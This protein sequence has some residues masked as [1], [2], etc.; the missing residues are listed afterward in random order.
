MKHLNECA[1]SINDEVPGF[2]LV[3]ATDNWVTFYMDGNWCQAKVFM[4]K[5]TYGI[6]N[7]RVSKLAIIK[8]ERNPSEPFFE[9][10][11]YNYDRGLDFNNGA[12]EILK[13]ILKVFA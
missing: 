5:S 12:G 2:V 13:K 10:C 7:G 1:G 11:I 4:E 6:R 3:E 9:Q 8:G